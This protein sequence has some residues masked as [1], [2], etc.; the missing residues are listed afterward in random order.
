MQSAGSAATLAAALVTRVAADTAHDA[1]LEAVRLAEVDA[2][3]ISAH[4]VVCVTRSV[5]SKQYPMQ[6]LSAD[7]KY[8]N[9]IS[10][11]L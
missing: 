6:L 10:M 5:W 3:G 4:D 2:A 8:D 7:L 11:N 9:F 1:L